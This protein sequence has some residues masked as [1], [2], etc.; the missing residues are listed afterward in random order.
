MRVLVVEDERRIAADIRTALT[1]AGWVTDLS[2]DGEDAWFQAETQDYDAIILDLG[3]PRLDGLTVL[4]RLRAAGVATPVLIL[5][6]RDS[7]REKVEG[8][9]AGAD[10]YLAKPFQMEELLARLRAI[11]RR[12]AG[13]ADSILKAGQVELDTRSRTVTVGADA[14]SLSALEYRLLAQLMM[15]R[16]RVLSQS[17]LIEHVYAS[18]DDC[19]TNALE[20][21]VTRVRR[22]V[23]SNVIETRRGHGYC[24]AADPK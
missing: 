17:E 8:I 7:W 16:G 22:K 1:R 9:D 12:A 15:H 2:A 24:I 4:K 6:A 5:T 11:T 13:V 23:G 20:A 10:D 21:L 18:S 3:L 14:V 19:E